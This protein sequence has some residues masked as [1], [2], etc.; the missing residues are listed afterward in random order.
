MR[1]VEHHTLSRVSGALEVWEAGHVSCGARTFCVGGSNDT[2]IYESPLSVYVQG[3][4]GQAIHNLHAHLWCLWWL[5]LLPA[6]GA[7]AGLRYVGVA[8]SEAATKG[9]VNKVSRC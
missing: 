1:L 3:Q 4:L 8:G 9:N 6:T 5:F 7:G 2:C